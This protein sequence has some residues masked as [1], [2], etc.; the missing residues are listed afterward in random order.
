MLFRG[1]PL[2][3]RDIMPPDGLSAIRDKLKSFDL[4]PDALSVTVDRL[5]KVDHPQGK[6]VNSPCHCEPYLALPLWSW[7]CSNPFRFW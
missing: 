5:C 3:P 7:D 4:Q 2:A 6:P 1:D